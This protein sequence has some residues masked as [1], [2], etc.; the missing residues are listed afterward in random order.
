M[1]PHDWNL[2]A[3]LARAAEQRLSE[4]CAQHVA[5]TAWAFATVN[6]WDE[7]RFAALAR[8]AQRRLR[9]FSV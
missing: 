3:A 6:H 8:A 5:N 9:S 4:V 2:F 7:D 1:N